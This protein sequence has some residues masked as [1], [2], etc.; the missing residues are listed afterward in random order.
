MSNIQQM[1]EAKK[2]IQEKISQ[3]LKV[4]ERTTIAHTVTQGSSRIA[5]IPKVP[6]SALYISYLS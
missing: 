2:A 5:H 3:G 6:V 1:L 4:N